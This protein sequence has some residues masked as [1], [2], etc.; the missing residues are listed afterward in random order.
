[1]RIALIAP[2]FIPVPPKNYGGTELFIGYLAN[3][4]KKL[5]HSVVVYTNGEATVPVERRWLYPRSEW[6]IKGEVYD[7]LK[8]INHTAWSIRDASSHT[9][10]IHLNNAPGLSHSRF[11]SS[12]FVYTVHHPQDDGLSTFYAHYP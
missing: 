5:G 6:P 7:S 12:P 3:G 4:L 8:D 9:D 10:L 1:M 2:P 11:V